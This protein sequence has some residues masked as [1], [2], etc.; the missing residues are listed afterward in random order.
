[1]VLPSCP[2]PFGDLRSFRKNRRKVFFLLNS[3]AARWLIVS[4]QVYLT[5]S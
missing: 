4:G 3:T 2:T 1:M 5:H